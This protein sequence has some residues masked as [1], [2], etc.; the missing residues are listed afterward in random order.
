M[1]EASRRPRLQGP[2]QGVPRVAGV[3]RGPRLRAC[4]AA[5]GRTGVSVVAAALRAVLAGRDAFHRVPEFAWGKWDTVERVPTHG[6]GAAFRSG[7]SGDTA[8]QLHQRLR[9]A[10]LRGPAKRG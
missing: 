2:G 4:L 9:G 6:S 1:E 8:G 10:A 3:C 7:P 5:H